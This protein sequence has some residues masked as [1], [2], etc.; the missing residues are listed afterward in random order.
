MK[1]KKINPLHEKKKIQVLQEQQNKK[2]SE[3]VDLYITTK[4]R[5][6][7]TN[8]KSEQQW[9][10][11]I[12]TY[13]SPTL[14][15]KPFIHINHDDIIQVLQPIWK[16]KT[17][18]ARRIQQRL[19][20]IFSFAKIRNWY[21]QENPASWKDHLV[22]VL[23]DP[24]KMQKIKHFASLPYSRIVPFYKEL[25]DFELLSAYALRLLILT[26]TRTKEVTVELEKKRRAE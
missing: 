25:C 9:R 14:D 3:I 7:W 20:R 17:E 12:A 11:S 2:F 1:K 6:E 5:D 10:N 16:D 26:A 8:P 19:D 18:T 15:K 23:S 21:T 24:Y 13:A 4:K 22:Y